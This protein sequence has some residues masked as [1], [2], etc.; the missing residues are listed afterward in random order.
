[1]KES[2]NFVL[3]YGNICICGM[4]YV[5][6]I[7]SALSKKYC[8]TSGKLVWD[9]SFFQV[10]I[11]HLNFLWNSGSRVTVGF[12][13]D[14]QHQNCL[15]A[16][17]RNAFHS[18]ERRKGNGHKESCT[19]TTSAYIPLARTSDMQDNQKSLP[20]MWVQKNQ[21]MLQYKFDK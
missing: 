17:I 8:L 11:S 13:K 4:I 19:L 6:D 2:K 14:F 12:W 18:R 1:M 10:E 9:V 20:C 15:S 16:V 3:W 21:Q 7:N 5:C